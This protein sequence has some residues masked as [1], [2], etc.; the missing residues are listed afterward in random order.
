VH[1]R[2]DRRRSKPLRVL[3]TQE[4]I[5]HLRAAHYHRFELPLMSRPAEFLPREVPMDPYSLGLLLGDG[6]LSM[7]TLGFTT[8]DPELALAL[9]MSIEG[10]EARHRG[11]FDYLLRQR[12]TDGGVAVVNPVTRAIRDLDLAGALSDRKSVG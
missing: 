12:Q 1:T 4:M 2:D 3:E 7:K 9:E 8:A 11:R 10:I 5:G 6:C